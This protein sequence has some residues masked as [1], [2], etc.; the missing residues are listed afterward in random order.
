M[1]QPFAQRVAD[2]GTSIFTTMTA[3]SVQHNAINLG[4]GF[5]DFAAPAL[6]KQS[7]VDAILADHNQY[8][9]SPG[10]LVLREAVAAAYAETYGLAFDPQSEVTITSGATEA[11]FAVMQAL[12]DPGDEVIMF[13]PAYDGYAPD[14]RMAGGVPR[15][16]ALTP[17]TSVADPQWHFDASALRAAVGPRTR[18]IIINTPHNPTGKVYTQAELQQI[19]QLCCDHDLIAIADEVYDRLV[20][21][22][23]HQPIAALPG[24]RERTIT[25]NST[26]KT[27]SAT[28]WKIGYTL[29]PPPLTDAIRRA[30]QFITF[31]VPHPLQIGMAAAVQDARTSD[32]YGQLLGDYRE[33]RTWL[34]EGLEGAGLEPW[35]P[36]GAYF[37]LTPLPP[38]WDD[39]LAFC[40]HL[41]RSVG[42]AAIPVSGF[43]TAPPVAHF[44]RFCFAKTPATLQAAALRLAKLR[45]M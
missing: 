37:V 33:R 4:Q 44:V 16:V 9:P 3:L 30:H 11:L 32:Y 35:A 28:G 2:I 39:D 7:A 10:A 34:L 23:V 6:V 15:P 38:G 12:L 36:E 8:A 26:G 13:D 41:V 17:P 5:P 31:A 43:Y 25:I 14:I 29:A 42:V 20:F 27:F 21:E 18:A 22:G 45:N 40:H 19:A 24:M 1:P